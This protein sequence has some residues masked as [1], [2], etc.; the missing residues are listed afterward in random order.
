MFSG[1]AKVQ[2]Y[3]KLLVQ[4]TVKVQADTWQSTGY[5]LTLFHQSVGGRLDGFVAY[6]LAALLKDRHYRL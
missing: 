5:F 2:K 3:K 6:Y 1:T 4:G